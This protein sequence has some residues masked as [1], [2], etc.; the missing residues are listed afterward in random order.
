MEKTDQKSSDIS[1]FSN[2]KMEKLKCNI[3]SEIKVKFHSSVEH[4]LID[5]SNRMNLP[6]KFI[7]GEI[8]ENGQLTKIKKLILK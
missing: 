3:K 2:V 1:L 8:Y 4:K 7:E 6:E 5:K